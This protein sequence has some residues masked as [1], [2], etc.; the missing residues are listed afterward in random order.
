ME[1]TPA[2]AAVLRK[3][4]L[5]WFAR[6][7]PAAFSVAQVAAVLQVDPILDWSPNPDHIAAEVQFLK[8]DQLLN[9]ITRPMDATEYFAISPKGQLTYESLPKARGPA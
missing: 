6:R 5:I 8:D 3:A 4:L 1:L 2:Q 9:L 7:R